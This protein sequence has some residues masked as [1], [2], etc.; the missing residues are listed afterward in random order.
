MGAQLGDGWLDALT[1]CCMQLPVVILYLACKH[2]ATRMSGARTSADNWKLPD[3][4]ACAACTALAALVA[5]PAAPVLPPAA[6]PSDMPCTGLPP[7]TTPPA[8]RMSC[9]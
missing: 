1:A 9:K 8:A 7:P 3:M 5:R 2:A 6:P 4:S